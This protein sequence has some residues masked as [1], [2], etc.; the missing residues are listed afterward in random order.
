[1]EE[2]AWTAAGK[3]IGRLRIYFDGRHGG[4]ETTFGQDAVNDDDASERA[5]RDDDLHPILSLSGLYQEVRVESRVRV[6]AQDAFLMTLVPKTGPKVRLSVSTSTGLILKR[7]TEGE[8]VELS[9]YRLVDGE[10]I[11]FRSTISDALGE[12]TVEVE[13]A[14]FGVPIEDTAFAPVKE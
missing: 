3:D 10:R 9:D 14:R 1:M 7:E 8:T 5:R 13:Q 12:T 6:G 2:E 11:P 4:Q